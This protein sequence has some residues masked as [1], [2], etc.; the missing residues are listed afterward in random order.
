MSRTHVVW[1]C[2]GSVNTD[3]EAE[4]TAWVRLQQELVEVMKRHAHG[5]WT[6]GGTGELTVMHDGVNDQP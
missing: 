2:Y 6:D 5:S 1:R 4:V 3:H